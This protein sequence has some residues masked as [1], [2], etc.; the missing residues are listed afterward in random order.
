MILNLVY[1]LLPFSYG[2]FCFEQ[3]RKMK[4]NVFFKKSKILKKRSS[5]HEFMFHTRLKYNIFLPIPF[6]ISLKKKKIKIFYLYLI[7][8]LY[9]IFASFDVGKYVMYLFCCIF[10]NV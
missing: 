2:L 10:I 8:Y 6:W 7:R 4:K 3:L 5:Q 1:V 9:N